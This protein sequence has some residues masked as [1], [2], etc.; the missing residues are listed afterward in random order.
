MAS[1]VSP[2]DPPSSPDQVLKFEPWQS[3]VD[4][5][6]WA[7][8]ARRKLDNFGLR[9]DPVPIDGLFACSMHAEV[10]SPVA[11]DKRSFE[12]WTSVAN[13]ALATGQQRA[14]GTLRN[15]NT[16]ERFKEYDRGAMLDESADAVWRAVVSGDA[17][18]DPHLLNQ[19]HMLTF[20]DL[21]KWQFTYWFAFPTVK[22]PEAVRVVA[23]QALGT[24]LGFQEDP[25]ET[26]FTKFE[27]HACDAF[28]WCVVTSENTPQ[29]GFMS[30][31]LHE[32]NSLASEYGPE[33]VHVAFMD[34]S[35]N[36]D[37]PGWSARNLLLLASLTFDVDKKKGPRSLNLI[38]TRKRNGK[39]SLRHSMVFH[40]TLPTIAVGGELHKLDPE[41][42]PFPAVGWELNPKGRAGPRRAD[43]GESMDPT[44]LAVAAA[45]LNLKLMPWRLLPEL[46][47]AKISK[48]KCLLIG[49]GT[50]GCSVARCL[51]GT[52]PH[53]PNPASLFA[54]TRLTLCFTYRKAGACA[55]SRSWITGR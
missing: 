5:T 34:S 26:S 32:F 50:L 40:V 33:N 6:F 53:F 55:S 38:A 25:V 46:D 49:A 37:H 41:K 22:L 27:Q 30:F 28:A 29:K 1:P 47:L 11:L 21:K 31:P 39:V 19:F 3:A 14:P 20:A 4:P 52:S 8:L 36:P 45:E 17:A 48:T 18:R 10:S 51:L 13:D 7:E 24:F 16:F 15:V 9:E 12:T 43:L 44:R 54:H 2:G 42:R 35:R 23:T